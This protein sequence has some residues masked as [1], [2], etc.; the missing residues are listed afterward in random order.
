[1]ADRFPLVVIPEANRIQEI[2]STLGVTD[3]LRLNG[4]LKLIGSASNSSDIELSGGNDGETKIT[5]SGASSNVSTITILGKGG[6]VNN[7]NIAKFEMNGTNPIVKSFGSFEGNGIT[8]I[9]GIIMWGGSVSGI[10]SGFRL[11]NGDSLSK[12]AN[13]NEFLALFNALGYIH[14]GSGD[15]FNIPNLRDKFVVGAHADNS[16]TTYPQIKP[17]ATG[18]GADT[19]LPTHFHHAF[20]SGNV[21]ERRQDSNLSATNFPSSGTGPGNLNEAYNIVSTTSEPN[22]GK[23]SDEGSA[24]TN[25][26]LP[27]YY[28]LAF[29]MR[30]S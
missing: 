3:N 24:A 8:P 21:G 4:G 22:V 19:T 9:G 6:N 30:V 27:P 20:R 2:A 14:G 23:T 29:I 15:N 11:C 25:A 28:A 13:N 12:S 17:G 26:N 1:M 16:D 7:T 18:G 5:I 10:P